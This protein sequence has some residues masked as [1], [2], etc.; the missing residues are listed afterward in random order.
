MENNLIAKSTISINVPA[1]TVWNALTNPAIIKQYLF[2][3]E[4]IS[5]WKEGSSITYKGNWQGKVYEDKGTIIKVIPNK[6]L[7]STYWS[8]MS[9][10]EDVPKNYNK[11][12]W[13]L[14]E[15]KGQTTVNLLQDNIKTEE[16]RKHSE[17]NWNLVLKKLKEIL[18]ASIN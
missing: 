2:G 17:E 16:S 3:T 12:T 13:A 18:E 11:V 15:K 4:A 5:D 7:T 1:S 10:L 8:S 14:S 9:G 6:L